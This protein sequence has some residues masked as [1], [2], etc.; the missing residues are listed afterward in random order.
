[1]SEE[2]FD[3]IQRCIDDASLYLS[4]REFFSLLQDAGLEVSGVQRADSK[5]EEKKKPKAYAR[6][7]LHDYRLHKDLTHWPR[8]CMMVKALK[9]T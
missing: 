2:I 9:F 7:I 6:L 1:M 4:G 8:S 3:S 5:I